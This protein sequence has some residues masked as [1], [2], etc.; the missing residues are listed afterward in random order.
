MT[1]ASCPDVSVT[2]S[3]VK[4]S[5]PVAA[6]VAGAGLGAI[7][8]PAGLVVSPWGYLIGAAGLGLGVWLGYLRAKE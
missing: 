8:L 7:F 5:L 3:G 1:M 2:V 6:L 4:V